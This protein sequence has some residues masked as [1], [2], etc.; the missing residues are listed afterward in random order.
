MLRV[1]LQLVYFTKTYYHNYR[2]G[3]KRLLNKYGNHVRINY[4][5]FLPQTKIGSGFFANDSEK[6]DL[7]KGE[8]IILTLDYSF[9]S[10]SKKNWLAL[11]NHWLKT[12]K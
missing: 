9:K 2:L 6:V 1:N 11:T 7:V 12:L 8:S 4:K 5:N 10:N 3:P